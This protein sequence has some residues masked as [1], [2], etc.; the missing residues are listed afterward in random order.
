MN[1]T[2]RNQLITAIN[3]TVEGLAGIAQALEADGW[4]GIEDHYALGGPKPTPA[5]EVTTTAA[6]QTDATPAK[7]SEPMPE[8]P[9]EPEVTLVQLRGVLTELSQQGF[10]GQIQQMIR[11]VGAT[12][13]SEVDPTHYPEL[14]ARAEELSHA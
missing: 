10:T 2:L 12:K 3:H 14:L 8:P 7:P 9:A 13:L 6:E 4:D 1:P 11:D 5:I